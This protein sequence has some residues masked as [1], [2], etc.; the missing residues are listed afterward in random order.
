MKR[1]TKR[2]EELLEEQ[3][4]AEALYPYKKNS[5]EPIAEGAWKGALATGIM[6][7]VHEAVTGQPVSARKMLGYYSLGGLLGALYGKVSN[8]RRV[9]QAEKA[10]EFLINRKNARTYV[11]E[12][13]DLVKSAARL[14]AE[15]TGVL[16]DNAQQIATQLGQTTLPTVQKPKDDS[17]KSY[18]TNSAFSAGFGGVL[19]AIMGKGGR[20]VQAATRGTASGLMFGLASPL[21]EKATGGDTQPSATTLVASGALT[22]AAEPWVHYIAGLLSRPFK[23]ADKFYVHPDD[24]QTVLKAL[25]KG[26]PVARPE[27]AMFLKGRLGDKL[28]AKNFG[29]RALKTTA[30]GGLLGGLFGGALYG[31]SKLLAPSQPKQY[32]KI[33]TSN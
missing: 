11:K 9:E 5:I 7:T 29:L 18:L 20:R 22:G 4:K 1:L 17:L 14:S 24:K 21:L 13:S 10:R 2:E 26:E 27:E 16:I 3:A 33:N 30:K 31:L 32:D 12:K 8:D 15:E 6:R 23:S 28:E 25:K 19:G